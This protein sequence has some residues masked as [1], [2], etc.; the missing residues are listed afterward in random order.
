[1]NFVVPMTSQSSCLNQCKDRY[2]GLM[3]RYDEELRGLSH[4]T[5]GHIEVKEHP[6]TRSLCCST[7]NLSCRHLIE[8]MPK[9][10]KGCP[11]GGH[12]ETNKIKSEKEI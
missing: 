5:K 12:N 4:K 6:R 9:T 2:E 3:L 7:L 10:S 8:R 11:Q 1:M